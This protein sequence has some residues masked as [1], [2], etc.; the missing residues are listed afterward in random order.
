MQTN[1][2]N[3]IT[4]LSEGDTYSALTYLQALQILDK[5]YN[6]ISP[7]EST[8]TNK[9]EHEKLSNKLIHSTLPLTTLSSAVTQHTD[10]TTQDNIRSRIA[11]FQANLHPLARL[12]A[13][14]GEAPPSITT[15]ENGNANSAET[16]TIIEDASAALAI[17]AS[18]DLSELTEMWNQSVDTDMTTEDPILLSKTLINCKNRIEEMEALSLRLSSTILR[19]QRSAL[20]V[21]QAAGERLFHASQV[22]TTERTKP[23]SADHVRIQL[24]AARAGATTAKLRVLRAELRA[25]MYT[26]EN[27]NALKDISSRVRNRRERIEE[28]LEIAQQQLEECRNLGVPF[29]EL[30]NSY[31]EAKQVL[32]EKVWSRDQ[33]MN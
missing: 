2:S 14:L 27:V 28:Q 17:A 11:T 15:D 8:I 33:L 31:R 22:D 32:E 1:L 30:A 25:K 5:D 10:Q 4:A 7:S 16:A 19:T 23:D 24:L 20:N 29:E 9:E 21:Y 26:A 3:L 13:Q 18:T 6:R 12:H